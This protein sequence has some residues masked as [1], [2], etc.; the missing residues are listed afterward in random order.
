[1]SLKV[2][3]QLAALWAHFLFNTLHNFTTKA[4]LVSNRYQVDLVEGIDPGEEFIL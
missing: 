3:V 4:C 2:A 1:M